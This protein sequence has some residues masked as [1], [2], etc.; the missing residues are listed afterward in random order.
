MQATEGS[1]VITGIVSQMETLNNMTHS[2]AGDITGLGSLSD[3]IG[4]IVH[5]ISAIAEQTNLLALNAAIEA[6][7]AG[8]HGRG[9]AVVADEVRKLA[10]QSATATKDIELLIGQIQ[11]RI[12]A[13]VSSMSEGST[14]AEMA[15]QSVHQGTATLQNILGSVEQINRQV[16]SFTAGLAQVNSSGHDIASA[17]EEQAASMQ[18]VANSAQDLMDMGMKLQE[19]V[20]HFKLTD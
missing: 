15:L 19:L 3:E 8:E 13:I 17:T 9:F 18:E 20:Q 10:E 14:Q 2:L 7:R 16:E 12:S 5:A 4:N 1:Q 6:A 11:N